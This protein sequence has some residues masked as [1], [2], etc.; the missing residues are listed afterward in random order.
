M[1][2]SDIACAAT[3]KWPVLRGRPQR[4]RSRLSHAAAICRLVRWR[5]G[6]VAALL[7]ALAIFASAPAS[8]LDYPTKPVRIILPFSAGGA[9]DVLCRI[10]AQ[11]L[12]KH[13]GHT[14][15]VENRVGGN[16]VVG[17]TAAVSSAPD[18]YT[19][20]YT[21]DQTITINP[22]LY[23]A[24]YNVERDLTPITLIALNPML[25][26]I[27]KDLPATT[28][29]EFVELA[30]AKP[31][32][33]SFGSSGAGSIQRLAMEYFAQLTGIELVHL[34]YRGSNETV[35]DMLGGNVDSTFNGV[36]NFVQLLKAGRVRALA[37]STGHRSK[38]VPDIPTVRE[39]GGPALRSYATVSWF[40]LFA[41]TGVPQDIRDRIQQDLGRVLKSPEAIQA[42]EARGFELVAS[43]ADEF[44]KVIA[45]DTVR[46]RD[47]ID[48]AGIKAQ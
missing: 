7:A 16:T 10:A 39:A 33:I 17:A 5:L 13:W 24:P 9:A 42:L 1:I 44:R 31:K 18:G 32:T 28:V 41:P 38:Q 2:A 11:A 25:L 22:L 15:I 19:L 45:E 14:V 43:T 20:F 40:G 35:A 21:G 4:G 12:S 47:V 8:A 6:C 23:P 48:K 36:S 34:P 46:W 3:P 26:A 27:K 30:K 29:G 37:V